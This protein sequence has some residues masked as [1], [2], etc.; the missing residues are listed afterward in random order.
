MSDAP[1]GRGE[2]DPSHRPSLSPRGALVLAAGFGLAGGFLDVAGIV[3]DKHLFQV[4]AYYKRGWFF[5]WTVP[6]GDLAILMVPG[7]LVAGLVWLRQGL[8]SLRAA[9]WLFATLALAGPLLGLPI[10]DSACWLLAAGL[11]RWIGRGVAALGPRPRRWAGRGLVGL[12]GLLVLI[13]AITMGRQALAEHRALARL[14]APTAGAPNVLLLV[15]DTVRAES[16]SLYGYGRPTT[17]D[18]TRWARRGV[19]FDRAVAPSSWTFPSH[20]CFFTGQWPYRLQAHWQPTLDASYPTL[21]EFLGRHG[22][23]TAGFVANT[24]YC[25]YESG[26]DRGFAHY[27]DYPLSW[28]MILAGTS[29]GRW[30]TLYAPHFLPLGR[31]RELKWIEYQ[32]RDAR[33]INRAFLDWLSGQGPGERPFFAF[34]NYLDAH[35]PFLVPEEPATHFGLRPG[36]RADYEA[37]LTYWD[38]DK[39]RLTPRDVALARDAYDDCI[40][41][42]DRQV[43]SL[44]D[45]LDRRGVL[46][47]TVVIITSDHGEDF[48]DHGV[49]NHGFSLYLHELLV[50][51]VILA[52]GA[53]AGFVVSDPVSLRDLPATVVDLLGLAGGSPFP[54]RS[55]AARWRPASGDRPATSPA[56]SEVSLP[57]TDPDPRHL[58]GPGHWGYAMSLVDGDQHYIRDSQESEELYDLAADPPESQNRSLAPGAYDAI[59]RLRRSILRILIDEAIPAGAGEK[60]VKRYRILLE[61][62]VP[63]SQLTG[64][65]RPAGHDAPRRVE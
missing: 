58:T 21:A 3:L 29:L 18:L 54:G 1:A 51:L 20:G 11:G 8:V 6:L 52:P 40:A 7:L 26:L 12:A 45:E 46:G 36:S 43:G 49:F 53:P 56:L 42:L 34:L 14:P 59:S 41:A 44:L 57:V 25:S 55:L 60:Y 37:L 10:Y 50:P 32:S 16:L 61:S 48:G 23:R 4:P 65:P 5:A 62:V 35:E 33:G 47:K 39:T 27:E 9:A 38:Q 15:L 64:E 28:G 22:Y 30:A 2:P 24:S 63:A 17:P 19:R 13:A 31:F